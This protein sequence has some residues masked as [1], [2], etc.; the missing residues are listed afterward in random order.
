MFLMS[1]GQVKT[2]RDAGICQPLGAR[3][4]GFFHGGGF[5]RLDTVCGAFWSIFWSKFPLLPAF[6]APGAPKVHFR[7][8]YDGLPIR[9]FQSRV[10]GDPKKITGGARELQ[11]VRQPTFRLEGGRYALH[12]VSGEAT[13]SHGGPVKK[14]LQSKM[15]EAGVFSGPYLPMGRCGS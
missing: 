11:G 2:E 3:E 13:G 12:Y 4:Q 7:Y 10:P 5:R 1:V 15:S 14:G 6:R 8:I 9:R